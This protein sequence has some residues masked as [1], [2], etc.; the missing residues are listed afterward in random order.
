MAKFVTDPKEAQYAQDKGSNQNYQDNV[1]GTIVDTLSSEI[2]P[3]WPTKS[4]FWGNIVSVEWDDGGGE[5]LDSRPITNSNQDVALWV[6]VRNPNANQLKSCRIG[7][8]HGQLYK[9]CSLRK[10]RVASPQGTAI[11]LKHYCQEVTVNTYKL[12]RDVLW[13]TEIRHFSF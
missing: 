10:T 13:S 2:G 8:I 6:E 12:P 9:D 11:F 4:L 5:H 1:V 3:N 7:D